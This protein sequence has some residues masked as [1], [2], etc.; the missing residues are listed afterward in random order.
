MVRRGGMEEK[1]KERPETREV[2]C[3]E[4]KKPRAG[5]EGRIQDR[6]I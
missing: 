4:E 2:G 6:K 1:R 3:K 5:E